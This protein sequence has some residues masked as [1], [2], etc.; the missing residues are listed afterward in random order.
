LLGCTIMYT[1]L[2]TLNFNNLSLLLSIPFSLD[3][4]ILRSLLLVGILLITIVLLFKIVAVPFHFLLYQNFLFFIFFLN[5]FLLL[6]Y[7]LK[8]NNY[9][10]FLGCFQ[11]FLDLFLR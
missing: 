6:H 11:F 5:G 3:L 2:G 9:C 1:C 4:F 7:F 8:L 10:F